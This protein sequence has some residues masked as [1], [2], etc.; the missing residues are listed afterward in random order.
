M[1]AICYVSAFGS[2]DQR[3]WNPTLWK[4]KTNLNFNVISYV[5]QLRDHISTKTRRIQTLFMVSHSSNSA[6]HLLIVMLALIILCC[7]ALNAASFQLNSMLAAPLARAHESTSV[8]QLPLHPIIITRLRS[9][10]RPDLGRDAD[11]IT[12]ASSFLFSTSTVV[13]LWSESSIYL[14][15]CGPLQL[16]DIIERT[17]YWMVLLVAC[18][19]WF[20]RVAFQQ[21]L[22]DTL[23]AQG[24]YH[25]LPL[26]RILFGWPRPWPLWQC[27][28]Q[29][30][31]CLIRF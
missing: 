17:A 24:K 20:C 3:K 18:I 30:L 31:R 6:T 23:Q 22:V 9:T 26:A 14:S 12:A 27:S 28:G 7:C 25:C 29:S 13:V 21:S 5:C 11:R 1:Y 2:W 19:F 16:P 15:S 4:L 8:L 10:P